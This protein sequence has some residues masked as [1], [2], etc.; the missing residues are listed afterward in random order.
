MLRACLVAVVIFHLLVVAT[1]IL[2]ALLLPFTAIFMDW[3]FWFTV[4]LVTPIESMIISLTFSRQ[5]CPITRLE[6]VIRNKLGMQEIGGF[7]GYY[8]IKRKWRKNYVR[9]RVVQNNCCTLQETAI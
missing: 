8:I 1:N 5:Q 3:P 4:L 6:N 2:A 9:K 7:I